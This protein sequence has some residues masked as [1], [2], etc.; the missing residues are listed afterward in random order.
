MWLRG[1]LRWLALNKPLPTSPDD[2]MSLTMIFVLALAMAFLT[3]G[4]LL[5]VSYAIRHNGLASAAR[6]AM[7]SLSTVPM[8]GALFF[9]V[10]LWS[11]QATYA[12]PP[13]WVVVAMATTSFFAI[14][15]GAVATLGAQSESKRFWPRACDIATAAGAVLVSLGACS[16]GTP[17]LAVAAT[18]VLAVAFCILRGWRPAAQ[19]EALFGPATAAAVLML[20]SRVIA[21]DEDPVNG[22]PPRAVQALFVAA[23]MSLLIA[24]A[25][26]DAAADPTRGVH[27][28]A[29]GVYTISMA[30]FY[31][32]TLTMVHSL[33]PLL[34][35]FVNY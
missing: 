35:K 25:A 7:T 6:E 21:V 11:L 9:G 31:M 22:H 20:T 34:F 18:A 29:A 15:G 14:G 12:E 8:L 17:P 5:A 27:A 10:W 32:S 2:E 19:A 24:A 16:V 3:T 13:V 4:A 26:G 28:I 30:A 1:G 23:T 33:F